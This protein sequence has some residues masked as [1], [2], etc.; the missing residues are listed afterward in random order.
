M[1]FTNNMSKI[2]FAFN[3]FYYDLVRDM[4]TAIATSSSSSSSAGTGATAGASDLKKAIKKAFSVK[5]M[6]CRVAFDVYKSKLM[7]LNL[8]DLST[9][10]NRALPLLVHVHPGMENDIVC[11][12]GVV[13]DTVGEPI[14]T[15]YLSLF[16]L[17]ATIEEDDDALLSM[18]LKAI[19]AWQSNDV[20]AFKELSDQIL[21]EDVKARLN[22][23]GLPPS[24]S[25]SSSSGT[26]NDNQNENKNQTENDFMHTSKI[27]SLARE[28]A[29]DLDL[30]DVQKPEDIL[31]RGIGDIVGKV[32]SKL[33]EKFQNG[34]I[35]QDDLMREAMQFMGG[36]GDMVANM[37]KMMGQMKGAG[38]GGF[39]FPPP[40]T[41]TGNTGPS[42][43]G[44]RESNATLE[45][46]RKK[47]N[48]KK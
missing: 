1:I 42:G 41:S 2:I 24:S 25:S 43:G 20:I 9:P 12:V 47:I 39:P 22:Q 38:G 17:I 10:E 23:L 44:D 6:E 8:L 48:S 45:R 26:T 16:A 14:L 13:L 5:E 11:S 27:G 15:S 31:N 30:G 33:Q 4:K 35:K 34:S 18:T 37:M 28:I 21:D 3:K 36:G 32:S 29:E 46:L 7:S 19:Q 40:G